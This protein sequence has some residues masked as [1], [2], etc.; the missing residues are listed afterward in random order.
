MRTW[1]VWILCMLA[2]D[3]FNVYVTVARIK[4]MW[5]FEAEQAAHNRISF[6]T[7]NQN[8]T[9]TNLMDQVNQVSKPLRKE[10]SPPK[11]SVH[12]P[13]KEEKVSLPALF[14]LQKRR[15]I[16]ILTRVKQTYLDIYCY[17]SNLFLVFICCF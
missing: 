5:D 12:H 2:Y 7:T 11:R 16:K 9:Q 3:I 4:N 13:Y 17:N 10:S 8:M 6:N 1:Y 14:I 15:T